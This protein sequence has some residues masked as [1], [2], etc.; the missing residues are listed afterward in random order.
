MVEHRWPSSAWFSLPSPR[1]T[2]KLP[3]PLWRTWFHLQRPS[4]SFHVSLRECNSQPDRRRF[5]RPWTLRSRPR[6]RRSE[7]RAVVTVRCEG[8]T[9]K[10]ADMGVCVCVCVF[11]RG[12]PCWV[13]LKG[14]QGKS[15]SHFVSWGEYRKKKKKETTHPHYPC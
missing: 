3:G 8:V 13:I 7:S 12:A 5:C 15:Q 14:N 2:W 10:H 11:F 6:R 4:R 9:H 1:L